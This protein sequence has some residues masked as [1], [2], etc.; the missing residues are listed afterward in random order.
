RTVPLPTCSTVTCALPRSVEVRGAGRTTERASLFLAPSTPEPR[1]SRSHRSRHRPAPLRARRRRAR[2]SLGVF[3][4]VR[5]T[6]SPHTIWDAPFDPPPQDR[7]N[8]ADEHGSDGSARETAN[9]SNHRDGTQ[10][11][12]ALLLR[13]GSLIRLSG[14]RGRLRDRKSV[15]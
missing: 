14:C 7:L 15:V 13:A 10:V 4:G 5:R 1:R 3:A 11:H 2:R 9:E 6:K 8:C 12:A